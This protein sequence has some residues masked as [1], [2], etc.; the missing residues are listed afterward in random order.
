MTQLL[1]PPTPAL[2]QPAMRPAPSPAPRP[3]PALPQF[4]GN[5]PPVIVLG[6]RANA[7]SVARQIGRLG[8]AVYALNEPGAFVGYSRYCRQI[9]APSTSAASVRSA[10][11]AFM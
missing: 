11:R 6:G 3:S 9:P 5:L 10:E 7:L 1:E 8:A 2:T 4:P